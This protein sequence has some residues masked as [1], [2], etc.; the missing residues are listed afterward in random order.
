MKRLAIVICTWNRVDML[1]A[2]LRFLAT[3]RTPKKRGVR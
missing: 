1:T 2:T 3:A